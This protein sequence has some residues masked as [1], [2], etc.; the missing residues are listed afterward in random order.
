M[1][2]KLNP[3]VKKPKNPPVKGAMGSGNPDHYDI[4]GFMKEAEK[5]RQKQLK[6]KK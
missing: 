3:A 4:K 1:K 2:K 5:L 6:K